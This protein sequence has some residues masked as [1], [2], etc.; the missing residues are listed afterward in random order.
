MLDKELFKK[1]MERLAVLYPNWK[2]DITDSEVM[3]IWH[4]EF[5]DMAEEE[6]VNKVDSYISESKYPPT[7]AGIK[8]VGEISNN[9]S[10]VELSEEE[11]KE[12]EKVAGYRD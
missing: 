2:I 3:K 6:F 5:E 12:A 1:Q 4:E 11:M 9:L 8:K 10:V 7:V